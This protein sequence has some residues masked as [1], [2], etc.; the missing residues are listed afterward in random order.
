MFDMEPSNGLDGLFDVV[1]K[2][3][4]QRRRPFLVSQSEWLTCESG[5][6]SSGREAGDLRNRGAHA[7]FTMG[8]PGLVSSCR[9]VS[10]SRIEDV[11]MSQA[12][13]VDR[14]WALIDAVK[15]AMVV[16][17]DGHGDELR[18]RPM[19]ARPMREENAIYFLTDAN[20]G[21][22]SELK[23]SSNVCLAFADTKA[24]NYVSVTGHASLSTDRALIKKFWSVA[25]KAFWSDANDPAIR[26]LCVEPSEA[27]YWEGSAALVTYVKMFVARVTSSKPNLHGNEKVPLPGPRDG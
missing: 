16:T 13:G 27:E 25:D 2:A 15:I 3:R 5:R 9:F 24:Q 18:A 1:W 14:V 20:S 22:I 17:H 19:A 6:G 8:A 21:K 7:A 11:P 12:S 26:L 10:C 4:R 23:E